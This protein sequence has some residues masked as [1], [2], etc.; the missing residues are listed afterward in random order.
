MELK[1]ILTLMDRFDA[2]QCTHLKFETEGSSI[3]LEKK[4]TCNPVELT[5]SPSRAFAAPASTEEPAE[6]ITEALTINAPLVGTFYHAPSPGESPFITVGKSIEAG[7]PIG[8][9]EAMKMMNEVNA[10][11]D[12]VIEEILIEDGHLAPYDAPLV[13]VREV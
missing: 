12:C 1:D 11:F 8:L 13:R 10:P 3:E 5:P 4:G 9:I 2:S 7:Q 6:D